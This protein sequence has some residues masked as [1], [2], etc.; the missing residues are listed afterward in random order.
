MYD[1]NPDV[2]QLL[3]AYI[4]SSSDYDGAPGML[5]ASYMSG[6]RLTPHRS[7]TLFGAQTCLLR[8][9]GSGLLQ[10]QH[11]AC[12]ALLCSMPNLCP[13]LEGQD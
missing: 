6:L 12:S 11:A 4:A 1:S 8:G 9:N 3:K 5:A 13:E 2:Q 7:D 10:P